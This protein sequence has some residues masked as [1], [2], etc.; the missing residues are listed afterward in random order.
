M[1]PLSPE[2][3]VRPVDVRP[4]DTLSSEMYINRRA[5]ILQQR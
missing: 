2:P 4:V 5:T 1:H 3:S